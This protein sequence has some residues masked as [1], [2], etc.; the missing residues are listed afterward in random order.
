MKSPQDIMIVMHQH[1]IMCGGLVP[2]LLGAGLSRRLDKPFLTGM[3]I[4]DHEEARYRLEDNYKVG[5]KSCLP[6]FHPSQDY[7]LSDLHSLMEEDIKSTNG[8]AGYYEML[9]LMSVSD[10]Q[11]GDMV[12]L[13]IAVAGMGNFGE[14]CAIFDVIYSADKKHIS[15]RPIMRLMFDEATNEGVETFSVKDMSDRIAQGDMGAAPMCKLSRVDD[16][17]LKDLVK[18]RYAERG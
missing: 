8:K 3:R 7:Y 14:T 2:I 15:M 13:P 10:M 5:L 16:N 11:D 9:P 6:A 4:I 18:Q 17:Y 12:A 1:E